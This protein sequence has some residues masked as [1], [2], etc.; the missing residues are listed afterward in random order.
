MAGDV[1]GVEFDGV[2]RRGAGRRHGRDLLVELVGAAGG[3]HDNRPVGE[4]NRE[5]DTDLAA[6]P[7]NHHD[8]GI[9][10]SRVIHGSDYVLR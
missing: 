4:P 10:A 6:A 5:F 7:E 9:R 1:V 3:Q 2:H 8:T